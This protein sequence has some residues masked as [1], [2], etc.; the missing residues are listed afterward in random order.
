[1]HF[2]SF[3]TFRCQTLTVVRVL[4]TLS[5]RFLPVLAFCP[6]SYESLGH[7]GAVQKT[8]PWG[9]KSWPTLGPC[10]NLCFYRTVGQHFSR[11]RG[12][13]SADTILPIIRTGTGT[14]NVDRRACCWQF[15]SA[16]V[17]MIVKLFPDH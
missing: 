15:D 12:P 7:V 8:F 10:K 17:S 4:A 16:R 6:I 9:Q 2:I 1:M 11:D 5:N 13:L 3:G 14:M